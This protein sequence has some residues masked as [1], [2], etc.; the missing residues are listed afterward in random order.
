MGEATRKQRADAAAELI[1][2]FHALMGEN[3]DASGSI[4]DSDEEET[5]SSP[6]SE[7]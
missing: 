3:S 6:A 7:A 2:R 4:G 5:Q 1:T